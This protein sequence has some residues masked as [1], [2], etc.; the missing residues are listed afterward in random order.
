[1]EKHLEIMFLKLMR[2]YS[3]IAGLGC[4]IISFFVMSS[5]RFSDKYSN[6][7]ILVFLVAFIV[8]SVVLF[9]QSW[10]LNKRL[11]DLISNPDNN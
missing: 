1:M 11:K 4:L 7:G 8:A 2:T 3:F 5:L 9:L 6:A 10:S